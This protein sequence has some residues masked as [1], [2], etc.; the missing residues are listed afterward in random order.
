MADALGEIIGAGGYEEYKNNKKNFILKARA[1]IAYFQQQVQ[2]ILIENDFYNDSQISIGQQLANTQ[3]SSYKDMDIQNLYTN[4]LSAR[5]NVQNL[6]Q[7]QKISALAASGYQILM[8][9]SDAIRGSNQEIK[10][11]IYMEKHG[12]LKVGVFNLSQFT[13]IL[14]LDKNGNLMIA[15]NTE[16]LSQ[17]NQVSVLDKFYWDLRGQS[18][19]EKEEFFT[20]FEYKIQ[21]QTSLEKIISFIENPY[22]YPEGQSKT[23]LLN[24]LKSYKF[25]EKEWKL[26][27]FNTIKDIIARFKNSVAQEYNRGRDTERAA[28]IYNQKNLEEFNS[29]ENTKFWLA[30]DFELNGIS[31]QAK[32]ITA[33]AGV[34]LQSIL[35]GMQELVNILSDDNP[36]IKQALAEEASGA[37]E[38]AYELIY[39]DLMKMFGV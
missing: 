18:Q 21:K 1:K 11:A 38:K 4:F 2:Q 27:R 36:N 37:E 29:G 32:N 3:I 16:V 17:I 9:L 23:K 26:N 24:K 12:E 31:Y 14:N 7:Q 5:E 30:P 13:K 35:S 39:Q 15:K 10:Y 22:N 8:E 25:S 28:W 33:G 20:W 6:E 19:K 34:Q